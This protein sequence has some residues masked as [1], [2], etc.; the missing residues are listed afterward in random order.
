MT[1]NWRD[2]SYLSSGNAKQRLVYE[3]LTKY[4]LLGVLKEFDPA[5]ITPICVGLDTPTSDV[6]IICCCAQYSLIKEVLQNNFA[7]YEN[8][9]I[10]Y[11][12]FKHEVLVC[13]FIL[14]EFEIE[15]FTSPEPLED[16]YGWRHL[17]VMERLVSIGGDSFRRDIVKLK[18]DGFKTEPAIAK[19]L[20][21]QGE[22]YEAVAQLESVP[23]VKLRQ[24]IEHRV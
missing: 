23:D 1:R 22:P 14:E 18:K 20:Q 4:N 16:Q 2:I 13:T 9:K 5:V 12:T 17:S 19:R 8:F 6:D 10:F 3:L 7:G 21:L 15:I 24:L 11:R